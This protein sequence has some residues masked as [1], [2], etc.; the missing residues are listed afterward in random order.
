MDMLATDETRQH[1]SLCVDQLIDSEITWND[2]CNLVAEELDLELDQRV[3]SMVSGMRIHDIIT[4][5][6]CI[7]YPDSQMVSNLTARFPSW[8]QRLRCELTSAT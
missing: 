8:M 4:S 5:V 1:W 6:G 7:P 2:F 3:N